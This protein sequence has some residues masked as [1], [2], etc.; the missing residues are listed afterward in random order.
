MKKNDEIH[1]P[2]EFK[3]AEE[4]TELDRICNMTFEDVQKDKEF[5]NSLT[6]DDM[7][8]IFEEIFEDIN[9]RAKKRHK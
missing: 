4:I 5:V 2:P 9:R 6:K 7:V 8:K 1:E 3:L